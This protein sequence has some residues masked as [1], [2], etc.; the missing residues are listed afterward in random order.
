M[1]KYFLDY[2][3][4]EKAYLDFCFEKAKKWARSDIEPDNKLSY[5]EQG[6]IAF[7]AGEFYRRGQEVEVDEVKAASFYQKGASLRNPQAQNRLGEAYRRGEGLPQNDALAVEWWCKAAFQR[8]REAS[9]FL[10]LIEAKT[11]KPGK[12][13]EK[14]WW[15]QAAFAGD[16]EAKLLYGHACFH[17]NAEYAIPQNEEMAIAWWLKAANQGEV[18]AMYKLGDAHLRGRGAAKSLEKANFWYEKA[19]LSGYELA[20]QKM[21]K[22]AWQYIL[23]PRGGGD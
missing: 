18:R 16:P 22:I 15:R 11:E 2:T 3:L 6:Q 13:Q 4:E 20:Q 14:G 19:A 17:G 5:S 9:H 7:F 1:I 8:N 21:E 12:L 23:K 10:D